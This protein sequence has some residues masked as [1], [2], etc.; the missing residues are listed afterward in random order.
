VVMTSATLSVSGSF[1]YF[2][3]RVGVPESRRD[4]LA[5]GSPFD[6]LQQA[7]LCVPEGLPEPSEPGFQA[8]LVEIVEA[9]ARTLGGR[10][11]VLF[12][13]NDQ[14][15]A[16]ADEL[17]WR[18]APVGIE[19]MAQ[20]RGG[21]SRRAMVE[22]FR[23][24]PE[25]VLCGTNSF[26]EGVDLPGA[27]LSCVVIVR[28]PFRPPGDPVQRARGERLSDSFL[29]LA[30]PEAVLRLKQGFGRLIRRAGDRGAVVILDNRVSTRAYGEHFLK[31]LPE[32][33]SFT[34]PYS[35]MPAAVLEWI[36]DRNISFSN[37]PDRAGRGS[38]TGAGAVRPR[39]RRRHRQPRTS[40]PT[41]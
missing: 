16:V 20:T 9:L 36:G 19:V 40:P 4:E 15:S 8:R 32:C 28:L 11:L 34:G 1:E 25:A 3:G 41:G 21:G 37:E 7:L 33:A 30:L 10:T 13:S 39:P 24:S 29:Q 27:G 31:S 2:C 18:L 17:T 14:L 12:T 5:L 26:W 6:F 35:E 38:A 23:S 22:R